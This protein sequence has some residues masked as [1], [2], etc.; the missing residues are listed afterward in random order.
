VDKG[1]LSQRAANKMRPDADDSVEDQQADIADIAALYAKVAPKPKRKE[2]TPEQIEEQYATA[3]LDYLNSIKPLTASAEFKKALPYGLVWKD[4]AGKCV[5]LGWK[6][7]EAELAKVSTKKA[8]TCVVRKDGSVGADHIYHKRSESEY[9]KVK[10]ATTGEMEIHTLEVAN[11]RGKVAKCVA[12]KR[13]EDNGRY[14]FAELSD[15]T[16]YLA[17]E[18]VC[19][20]TN[21]DG[22]SQKFIKTMRF[23]HSPE[24]KGDGFCKCATEN[25]KMRDYLRVKDEDGVW[26]CVE[27]SKAL[28]SFA[29][30]NKALPNGRCGKHAKGGTDWTSVGAG[31]TIKDL[32]DDY[33]RPANRTGLIA[34]A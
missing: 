20:P 9:A 13:G 14:T 25:K 31:W 21:A 4:I 11:K 8:T 33:K 5:A 32:D 24:W 16:K 1:A 12:I 17:I 10:N 26:R 22:L 19:R 34:T 2:L 30:N 29:C 15:T 28:P 6:E 23:T 3:R 7:M 27:E 18:P